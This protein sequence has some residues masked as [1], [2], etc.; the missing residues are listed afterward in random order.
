MPSS[1]N[2]KRRRKKK[3]K[4]KRKSRSRPLLNQPH[5]NVLWRNEAAVFKLARTLSNRKPIA[6]GSSRPR[7]SDQTPLRLAHGW[8]DDVGVGRHEYKKGQANLAGVFD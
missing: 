3:R 6:E 8:S 1:R 2:D 5:Q 7:A 4:R